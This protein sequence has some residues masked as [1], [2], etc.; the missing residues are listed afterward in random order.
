M[1]KKVELAAIYN[2]W[3][4][5]V[6]LLGASMRSVQEGIDIFIIVYQQRSN[7]GE[8]IDPFP[9][10]QKAI[11]D[12]GVPVLIDCWDPDINRAGFHNET[13]KRN[14]GIDLA[15]QLGATHFLH[16]DCDEF[17]T[18]FLSARVAYL[19]TGA[20]GSVLRLFTYFKLPTLRF[21][22]E[23]GYFVPFIHKLHPNTQSGG[24]NYPFY[25]DP[26]RKINAENVILLPFHMHHMSWV[27][28]DIQMKIRNS[29]A[30]NNLDRGTMLQSYNNPACGPGFYVKD[31]EKT[32]IEVPDQFNLLP[33]FT[34][35]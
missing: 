27:R 19:N 3:A 4:D 16:M 5:S 10:I 24:P 34:P 31:Y 32:L 28:R 9:E 17:Y 22:T 13:V 25:V 21:D 11:A 30:K 6:E 26:T 29:S 12:I 15:Q 7:W 23:D 1:D 33:I 35:T 18:N 2:V 8:Y 14:R 20:D